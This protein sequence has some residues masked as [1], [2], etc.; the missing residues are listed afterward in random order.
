M[1]D[2]LILADPELPELVN[3]WYEN[4]INAFEDFSGELSE[5]RLYNKCGV[6]I[7][8]TEF[9]KETGCESSVLFVLDELGKSTKKNSAQQKDR[10][11]ELI[12]S[13]VN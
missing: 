13:I 9:A 2:M 5:D 1:E 10:A 7:L 8:G 12:K 3:G 4:S 11:V 6:L